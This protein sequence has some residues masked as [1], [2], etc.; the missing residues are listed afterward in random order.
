[1]KNQAERI[2][3]VFDVLECFDSVPAKLYHLFFY[4]SIGELSQGEAGHIVKAIQ[5]GE[6]SI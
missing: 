5:Q 4:V 6:K 1:M 3:E 2:A